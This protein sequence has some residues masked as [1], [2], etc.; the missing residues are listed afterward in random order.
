MGERAFDTNNNRITINSQRRDDGPVKMAEKEK[1]AT[2]VAAAF[3]SY[4][5][6]VSKKY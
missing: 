3:K 2:V 1:A 5:Q 6:T 4:K